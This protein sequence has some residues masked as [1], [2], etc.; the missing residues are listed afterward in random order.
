MDETETDKN[1]MKIL[2]K[3]SS[4]VIKPRESRYLDAMCMNMANKA[5]RWSVVPDTG[6]NIDANGYYTAPVSEGVYEVVAQ[7]VAYPDIKASIMV[8]VRE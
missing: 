4:L 2:I 7:S 5:L 3:P 8:V 6:G 1:E